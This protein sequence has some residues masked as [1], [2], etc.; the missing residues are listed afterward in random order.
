MASV[1]IFIYLFIFA[2]NS[3]VAA[4]LIDRGLQSENNDDDYSTV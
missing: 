3:L 2:S 4:R 1:F